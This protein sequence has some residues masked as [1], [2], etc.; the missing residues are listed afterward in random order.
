MKKIA[1]LLLLALCISM[2]GCGGTQDDALLNPSSS[3]SV[4]KPEY[5]YT[6]S[7]PLTHEVLGHW[8]LDANLSWMVMPLTVEFYDDGTCY[9]E[10]P[11]YAMN[12]TMTL[13]WGII[14]DSL[15]LDAI[16][17]RVGVEDD[18]WYLFYIED[19]VTEATIVQ[20][21]VDPDFMIRIDGLFE[22]GYDGMLFT[23][24]KDTE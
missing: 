9:A 3:E 8:T 20:H 19:E 11:E 7:H 2:C 16:Y 22:D 23:M 14:P 12:Q 10:F 1:I 17:L 6:L 18:V 13:Y 5:D 15:N 24:L 21:S 4:Q